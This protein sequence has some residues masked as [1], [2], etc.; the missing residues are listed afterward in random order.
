AQFSPGGQIV[1]IG[2]LDNSIRLIDVRKKAEVLLLTGHDQTV[3][4]IV[5]RPDGKS[6]VS[7]SGD[8]TV[9]SW[10]CDT[11][12]QQY[13]ISIESTGTSVALSS[14]GKLAACGRGDGKVLLLDAKSG[15]V[16][17]G[18]AGHSGKVIQVRFV[19]DDKTLVSGGSEGSY[20]EWDLES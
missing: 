3:W 7:A 16:S 12:K 14:D 6:L 9:R 10:D 18:F 17:K 4:S 8:G 13:A 5:F 1:A 2:A 20:R 11:G 19:R 15:A